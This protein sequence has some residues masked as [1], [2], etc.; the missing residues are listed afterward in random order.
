MHNTKP[1]ID[2]RSLNGWRKSSYSGGANGECLEVVDGY[3]AVPVRDSK[4]GRTGPTVVFSAGG[5]ASFVEAVKDGY[6]AT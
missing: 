4:A 1:S 6:L 5:W 3:A 2:D